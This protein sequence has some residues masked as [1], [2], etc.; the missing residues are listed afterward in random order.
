MRCPQCIVK[1]M[2]PLGR[3][4]NQEPLYYCET[5]RTYFSRHVK[6]DLTYEWIVLGNP[7]KEIR[8][9]ENGMR[10]PSKRCKA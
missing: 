2:I 5:C 3:L 8:E 9:R 4:N 10:D 6:E 7:S 1:E